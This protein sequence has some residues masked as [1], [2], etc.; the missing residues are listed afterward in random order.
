LIRVMTQGD[1]DHLVTSVAED[2]AEA[3]RQAAG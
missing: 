2:L 3:I 1:D